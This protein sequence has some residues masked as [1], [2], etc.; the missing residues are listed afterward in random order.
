MNF[1]MSRTIR[2]LRYNGCYLRN[3]Y[4]IKMKLAQ[5]NFPN[6]IKQMIQ[7]NP[8]SII[9]MKTFIKLILFTKIKSG[10]RKS[11]K[12]LSS[13]NNIEEEYS[14]YFKTHCSIPNSNKFIDYYDYINQFEHSHL[15]KCKKWSRASFEK[16]KSYSLLEKTLLNGIPPTIFHWNIKRFKRK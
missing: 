10:W 16:R 6:K 4:Q 12:I 15:S 2:S 5:F 1:F 13:I 9:F 11:W 8:F 3:E 14:L 7:K